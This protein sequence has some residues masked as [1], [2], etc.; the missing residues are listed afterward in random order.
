MTLP[1]VLRPEAQADLLAA[2]DWYEKKRVGL[3]VV[4]VGDVE[5]ILVRISEM[6]ELH[7]VALKNI[8]RAKVQRFPYMSFTTV[9]SRIGSR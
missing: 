9:F 6:P 1:I 5:K 8:R 7:A 3:S 4:F 2:R